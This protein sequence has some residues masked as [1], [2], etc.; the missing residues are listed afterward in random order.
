MSSR[1]P[2]NICCY[3]LLAIVCLAAY[4]FYH[5]NIDAPYQEIK[6]EQLVL[7]DQAREYLESDVCTN[8]VKKARLENYNLCAVSKAR[9]ETRV[10]DIAFTLLLQRWKLCGDHSCTLFG[11]DLEESLRSYVNIIYY[12]AFFGVFMVIFMVVMSMFGRRVAAE[13]MPISVPGAFL[14]YSIMMNSQQQAMANVRAE[15]RV[16]E[17]QANEQRQLSGGSSTLYLDDG[18]SDFD[19][20]RRKKHD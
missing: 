17:N 18:H 3:S 16:Y 4:V 9:N 15:Q 6:R 13:Q 20:Q 14:Q 10:E 1:R 7:L 5:N 2:T 19:M 12:G 11:I 8:P